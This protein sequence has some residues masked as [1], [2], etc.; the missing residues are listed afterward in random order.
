M[1]AVDEA[2]TP[3]AVVDSAAFPGS[4][5]PSPS[6]SFEAFEILIYVSSNFFPGGGGSRGQNMDTYSLPKG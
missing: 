2:E 3:L 4:D 1:A 5:A 6:F